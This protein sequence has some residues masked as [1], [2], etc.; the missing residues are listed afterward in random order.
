[1]AVSN[2]YGCVRKPLGFKLIGLFSI[3]Q[4]LEG[5]EGQSDVDGGCSLWLPVA[6][7]G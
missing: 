4:G 7:A 2:T 3:I 6:P 5:G 1:M